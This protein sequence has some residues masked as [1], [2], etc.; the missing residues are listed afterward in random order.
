MTGWELL[1]SLHE[2]CCF[3]SMEKRVGV[4]TSSEL[5]RW[6]KQACLEVNGQALKD[7]EEV[8]YPIWSVVLFPKNNRRRC[9]LHHDEAMK[10]QLDDYQ[11]A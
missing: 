9:T 3:Q 8:T 7:N 11:R 4:A 10:A 5:R 6:C 1:R 2:V